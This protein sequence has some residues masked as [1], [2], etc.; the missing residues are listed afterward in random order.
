MIKRLIAGFV[1]ALTL[2][3]VS[4]GYGAESCTQT[5]H[6]GGDYHVLQMVWVTDGSGNFTA[7]ATGASIDGMVILAET[8]PSATVA[9]TNLYDITLVNSS[10]IDVFGGALTNRS[11]T[12]AEQTMPLQNANYT[13][14]PVMGPLTFDVT[15]AGNSK[16]GTLRIHYITVK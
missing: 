7:T 5:L 2:G 1:I 14:V 15:N 4:V 16:S 3:L 12:V 11:A 13:G 6:G 9:P 8:I 10:G